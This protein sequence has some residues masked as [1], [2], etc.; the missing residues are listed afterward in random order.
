MF[1]P[2]DCWLFVPSLSGLPLVPVL[3]ALW[4]AVPSFVLHDAWPF[5]G[6][7]AESAPLSGCPVLFVR[8]FPC[9]G[10]VEVLDFCW[11]L[12]FLGVS[13]WAAAAAAAAAAALHVCAAYLGA[14]HTTNFTQTEVVRDFSRCAGCCF[15]QPYSFQTTTT[16]TET[17]LVVEQCWRFAVSCVACL[18]CV[19]WLGS[20]AAMDLAS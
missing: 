7:G 14:V 16:E 8:F 11:A 5:G 10:L 4:S 12:C 17:F 6:A 2:I 13:A 9:L 20:S 15:F 1:I 3:L 18:A 19:A